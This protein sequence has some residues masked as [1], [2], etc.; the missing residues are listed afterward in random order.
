MTS[1]EVLNLSE[2]HMSFD[3][4]A[5]LAPE[6]TLLSSLHKLDVSG[7][8]QMFSLRGTSFAEAIAAMPSLKSLD[9]ERCADGPPALMLATLIGRCSDLTALYFKGNSGSVALLHSLRTTKHL[10]H[11]QISYEDLPRDYPRSCRS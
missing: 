8:Q 2:N 10:Q 3:A 9:V 5:A 7:N 1:L 6:L 11:L 4:A